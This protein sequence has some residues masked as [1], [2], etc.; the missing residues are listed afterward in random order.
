MSNQPWRN[1]RPAPTLPEV[2]PRLTSS[3]LPPWLRSWWP[4]A[5]WAC[6]IFFMS[7]DIFSAEHTARHHRAHP[8]LAPPAPLSSPHLLH[9]SHHPQVRPLHRI[10]HLLRPALPRHSRRSHRLA[11]DLGPHRPRHRRQLLLPR[12]NPPSLRRQSHRH[13]WDSLLDSIGA[14]VAYLA[15]FTYF[16]LREPQ[17]QSSP[18]DAR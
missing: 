7:T 2:Q 11:L 8:P 15:L 10:F 1:P 4:A 13:S 17:R 14:F 3:L 16:H 6:F 18:S 12:R 5:L 9:P